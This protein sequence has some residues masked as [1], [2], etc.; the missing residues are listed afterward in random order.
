[1]NDHYK[2]GVAAFK[3]GKSRLDNPYAYGSYAEINWDNGWQDAQR[4]P[5]L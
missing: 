3:I 5:N 4:C 2:E 1:M